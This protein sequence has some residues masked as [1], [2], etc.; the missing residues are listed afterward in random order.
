MTLP[1]V[2]TGLTHLGTA[3]GGAIAALSFAASHKVDLYALIDQLNVI[4]ADVTKFVA[5]ITPL[6]TAA[7]GIYRSSTGVRLT[8]LVQ[9]PKAVEIA[10]AMPV[11]PQTEAVADAL[12]GTKS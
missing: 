8:E 11:T 10:K 7:Y 3:L 12:K 1:Q 4:V 9:D 2:K 5:L 6:V